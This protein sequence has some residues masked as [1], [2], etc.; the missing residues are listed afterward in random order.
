MRGCTGA[1][2]M[3]VGEAALGVRWDRSCH[4]VLQ[5]QAARG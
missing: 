4:C 5:V 2:Q 3:M 1:G